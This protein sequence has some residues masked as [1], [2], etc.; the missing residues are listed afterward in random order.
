MKAEDRDEVKPSSSSS[1]ILQESQ[2]ILESLE[3]NNCR[4][5]EKDGN[6]Y[7]KDD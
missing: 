5:R 2:E 6:R 1:F 3:S 7:G 4:N